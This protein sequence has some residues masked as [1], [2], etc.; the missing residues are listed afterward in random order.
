ME[1]NINGEFD[2]IIERNK[3]LVRLV[4]NII[5]NEKAISKK[6]KE[7]LTAFLNFRR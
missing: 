6:V 3:I 7:Q 1:R 4:Q 2:C 5:K